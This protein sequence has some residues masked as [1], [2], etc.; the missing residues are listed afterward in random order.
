MICCPVTHTYQVRERYEVSGEG[1]H[2]G[3]HPDRVGPV[4]PDVRVYV[5]AEPLATPGHTLD[6]I[7]VGRHVPPEVPVSRRTIER[8]PRE[9]THSLTGE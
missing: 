5:S 3:R 6:D 7:C 8:L 9:R 2:H 4:P 1:N